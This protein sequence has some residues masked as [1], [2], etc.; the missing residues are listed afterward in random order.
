MTDAYEALDS[1]RIM[2]RTRRG[3]LMEKMARGVEIDS[4]REHVGRCKELADTV[5][6]ISAQ[7]KSMTGGQDDDE[8]NPPTRPPASKYA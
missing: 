2:L 4:Y 3:E 5:D 6:K 8:L 1:L 7:I